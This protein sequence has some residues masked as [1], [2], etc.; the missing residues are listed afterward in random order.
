MAIT[1]IDDEDHVVRYVSSGRLVRDEDTKKVRGVFPQAF[2]MRDDEEEL[3]VSW[4]EYFA[5]SERDQLLKTVDAMK[6]GGLSMRPK[7]GVAVVNVGTLHGA[8]GIAGVKV[9]VLHEP[10]KSNP[11]PA[12][13]AIRNLPRDNQELLLLI[14][15]MA[16]TKVVEIKE[17][18]PPSDDPKTHQ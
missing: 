16:C 13:A 2:Q 15:N 1:K 18:A 6:A 14:A 17:L 5:G 7:D 11:N 3:S 9:R 4:L 10:A 8:C 12:Y